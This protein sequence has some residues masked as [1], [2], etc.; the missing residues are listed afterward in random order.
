MKSIYN[1]LGEWR[2]AD[3]TAYQI[4]LQNKMLD[5]I[6]KT[7][8][9]EKPR[10]RKPNGYWN[11]FERCLED[12]K[13]YETV[14]DWTNNSI[15]AVMNSKKNGWFYECTEHIKRKT[16]LTKERCIEISKNYNSIAEWHKNNPSSYDK[17]RKN[18]WLDE[19]IG[20]MTGKFKKPAGYWTKERCIE[21]ANKHKTFREWTLSS[22]GSVNAATKNG[23]YDECTA[24][25]LKTKTTGYW[26]VKE[27]CIEE[28]LKYKNKLEWFKN[29]SGSVMGA[30]RNGW[31]AECTAHMPDRLKLKK[32]KNK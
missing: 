18:E 30:K 13:K 23:W 3:N 29:S 20:H 1:S 26:N 8:G 10:D 4:A 2:R 32:Y 19:C 16:P 24:H 22:K 5:I 7:F 27:N 31:Y 11:N 14:K 25:M 21:E 6:S 28:A 9:W 15:S 12:A 17:A